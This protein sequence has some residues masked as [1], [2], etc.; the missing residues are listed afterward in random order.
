MN[1]DWNFQRGEEVLEKIPSLGEVWMFSGT[2]QCGVAR[3][4]E[5]AL[6]RTYVE[7]IRFTM[8]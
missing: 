4:F 6:T 5:G 2:T 7:S 1:F 8:T 3:N